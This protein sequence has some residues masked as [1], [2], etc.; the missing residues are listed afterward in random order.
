MI[1]CDDFSPVQ[2]RVIRWHASAGSEWTPWCVKLGL[3]IINGS[4]DCLGKLTPESMC[5]HLFTLTAWWFQRWLLWLSIQLG[6]SSSQLTDELIFFRGVQTTNQS[7]ILI[8]L[9]HQISW[10]PHAFYI[11]LPLNMMVPGFKKSRKPLHFWYFWMRDLSWPDEDDGLM[12]GSVNKLWPY[13]SCFQAKI[14]EFS[15]INICYKWCSFGS[16]MVYHL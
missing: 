3:A 16:I 6:I 12:R 13:C 2:I 9:H 8:I 4:M 7:S 14:W 15:Q 10:F 1:S 5:L 11:F